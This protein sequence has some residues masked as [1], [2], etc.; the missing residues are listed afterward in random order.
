MCYNNFYISHCKENY[1]LLPMKA[2]Y[3][4]KFENAHCNPE[5]PIYNNQ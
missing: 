4:I 1:M 5:L 3:V 2:V